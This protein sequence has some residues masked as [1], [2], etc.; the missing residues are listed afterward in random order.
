MQ[1]DGSVRIK[2]FKE[3][4]EGNEI[5]SFQRPGLR[6]G[7]LT[8]SIS[9]TSPE[10]MHLARTR[11]QNGRPHGSLAPHSDQLEQSSCSTAVTWPNKHS[12]R[13]RALSQ[14]QRQLH[15]RASCA[16]THPC[17]EHASME[18]PYSSVHQSFMKGGMTQQ[19]GKQ[20]MQS[21]H[22]STGEAPPFVSD[23][24]A[25]NQKI[26]GQFLV[27]AGKTYTEEDRAARL[28]CVG[29]C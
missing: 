14:S 17:G 15:D 29:A 13:D 28:Q 18:P 12:E 22:C 27:T 23:D 11:T 3:G 21:L 7:D 20:R 25:N 19:H 8:D 4:N 10:E 6:N 5:A 2:Q 16:K 26:H 1:R 24:V 9:T